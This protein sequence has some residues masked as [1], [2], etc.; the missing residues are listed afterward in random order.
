MKNV[1]RTDNVSFH[2]FGK[3]LH[4]PVMS[5]FRFSTAAATPWPD[6]DV[7]AIKLTH[8]HDFQGPDKHEAKRQGSQRKGELIALAA[9]WQEERDFDLPRYAFYKSCQAYRTNQVNSVKKFWARWCDIRWSRTEN[10][11]IY[12][13]FVLI[14]KCW[15]TWKYENSTQSKYVWKC[16]NVTNGGDG[17]V[18]NTKIIPW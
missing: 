3:T 11:E 6:A 1:A 9:N 18:Y 16:E 5:P 17:I 14:N 13:Q 12:Q 15:K 4:R 8:V 10:G 7:W 2:V